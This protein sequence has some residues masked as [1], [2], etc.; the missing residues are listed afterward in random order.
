MR[1]DVLDDGSPVSQPTIEVELRDLAAAPTAAECHH[2]RLR[3]GWS[4][5]AEGPDMLGV[6]LAYSVAAAS[7]LAQAPKSN[8][9]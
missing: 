2:Q 7:L 1:G 3:M 4:L 8:T 9:P 5:V 6:H